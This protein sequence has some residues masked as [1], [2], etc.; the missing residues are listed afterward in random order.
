MTS[1]HIEFHFAEQH[2]VVVT[3]QFAEHVAAE[4]LA[5]LSE[6]EFAESP[7]LIAETQV[8]FAET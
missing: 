6:L 4:S 1:V 8:P 3:E 5:A 2:I 7:V